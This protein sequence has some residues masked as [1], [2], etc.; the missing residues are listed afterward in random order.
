LLIALEGI[1]GAGKTT[2][3]RLL[4]RWLRRAGL[5]AAYTYEPTRRGAGRIVRQ[6]LRRDKGDVYIDAL[7][8]AADR[9][10]HYLEVI[11]PLNEKGFI[12]I[13]D[14]FIHSSIAYQGAETGDIEWIRSINKHVPPPDLAIYIDVPVEVGLRRLRHKR[15]RF[16]KRRDL[17]QRV[18][19]LYLSLCEANE[20]VMIDGR[21]GIDDTQAALREIVL[22]HIGVSR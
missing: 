20:L 17:L 2:Q 5:R 14:R 21:G 15:A 10:S 16:E 19:E 13:S 9:L 6:R 4:V 7:L 3:A 18:R 1:D 12:I 8:F 11:H 22:R